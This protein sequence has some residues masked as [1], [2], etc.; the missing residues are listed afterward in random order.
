G[1]DRTKLAAVLRAKMSDP[2]RRVRTEVF[3]TLASY[4]DDASFAIVLK[5][6]ESTDTWISL[7]AAEAMPRFTERADVIVPKLLAAVAPGKPLALRIDALA[8]LAAPAPDKAV[9]AAAQLAQETASADARTAGRN[10]LRGLGA[11]G[12]A[13]LE[14]LPAPPQPVP[15]QVPPPPR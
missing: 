7:L 6:L 3:R 12:Q 11:A 2:D 8:S 13:R 5:G 1:L 10:G 9:D 14:G 4:K 15:P